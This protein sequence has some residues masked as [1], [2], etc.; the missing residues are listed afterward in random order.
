[1]SLGEALLTAR[2]AAGI[3]QSEMSQRIGITQAALSRYEHDIREP[4]EETLAAIAAELGLTPAFLR[5]TDRMQG[6]FH[7]NA[8][9]RRRASAKPSIWRKHEA[10]LNLYR[11]HVRHLL[12][13]IGLRASL[14]IPYF[15]PDSTI[16]SDAAR[17][18]RAQWRMPAG[19]V[20]NLV[21]WLESAGF[22]IFDEDLRTT[23]VDALSQLVEGYPL[24]LLNNQQPTDRRRLTLAH[25]LGHI[26][27][28][29]KYPTDDVEGDANQFAA[30]FLMPAETIR[31]QLR[32]L[33]I[34]KLHDLKRQWMVSMQA[35]IERSYQLEV[36]N[37]NQRTNFYKILG[38]KG[39]RKCEPLSNEL[40]RERASL[41]E[42]IGQSLVERGLTTQEIETL[43]GFAPASNKCPFLPERPSLRVV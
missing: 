6:A 5:S 12:E 16:P 10:Q 24:I 14:E 23:R 35:L 2:L 17:M 40:P 28:H 22:L 38:R 19:P 43:T 32:N 41:V 26:C 4:K 25:E 18:T 34:G 39:W 29:S 20:R 13:E 8:H 37:S 30:E 33:S 7:L 42:D 1:M 27:L 31:P 21:G 36:I 11:H 9:M 15:D 3:S